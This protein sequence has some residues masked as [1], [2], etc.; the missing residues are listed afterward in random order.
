LSKYIPLQILGLQVLPLRIFAPGYSRLYNQ[1]LTAN[2]F[3]S[4]VFDKGWGVIKF[5]RRAPWG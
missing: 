4:D 3:V 2:I 5:V 1:A